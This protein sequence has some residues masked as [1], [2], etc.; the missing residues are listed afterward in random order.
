MRRR[1]ATHRKYRAAKGMR[2]HPSYRASV[3]AQAAMPA[4]ATAP[5][6][7]VSRNRTLK[8]NSAI[9]AAK[10]TASVMAVDCK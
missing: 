5:H 7:W 2:N 1:R 3:P 4:P 10:K 9:N 6:P 8:Y